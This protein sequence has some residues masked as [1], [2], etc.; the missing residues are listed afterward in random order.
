MAISEKQLA[1]NRANAKKSTG[2]KT[3][4]GKAKS[5]LNGRRHGLTGAAFIRTDEDQEAFNRF[6]PQFISDLK[7]VGDVEVSLAQLI[8]RD[9]IRLH[10]AQAIEENTFALGHFNRAGVFEATHPQVHDAATQARVFDF[11]G[12]TF[13]NL[14]LY[15]SR[16]NRRMLA[17]SKELRLL[18]DRRKAEEREAALEAQKPKTFAAN[19]GAS[20]EPLSGFSN[21]SGL[22]PT[23]ADTKTDGLGFDFSNRSGLI[24]TEADTKTDSRGHG[25]GF[26]TAPTPLQA[27]PGAPLTPTETNSEPD[28][29]G[30]KAA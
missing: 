23:E 24:P 5:A 7:P 4:E 15:E 20:D 28:I 18:Q 3:E 2:P 6:F 16:I 1:A 11:D 8:A 14:S 21:R 27:S 26:S 25:F 13:H 12:K 9:H 19:A 30:Q 22:I 29:S 10:R 17:N